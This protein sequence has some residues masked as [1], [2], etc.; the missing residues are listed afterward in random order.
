VSKRAKKAREPKRGPEWAFVALV[1]DGQ[2][3]DGYG[4][5]C[6][7]C[8]KP[9]GEP[10]DRKDRF[11]RLGRLVL[12]ELAKL[13]DVEHKRMSTTVNQAGPAVSGDVYLLADNDDLLVHFS[14]HLPRSDWGDFFVRRGDARLGADRTVWLRW[15]ELRDLPAV[16][17]KIRHVLSKPTRRFKP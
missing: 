5:R 6:E 15:E 13:L 3:I 1:T 8:G 2:S 12:K 10:D 7:K 11:L 16:A 17:H 4:Q 9:T 14:H